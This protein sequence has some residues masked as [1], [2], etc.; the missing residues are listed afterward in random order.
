MVKIL[1][2]YRENKWITKSLPH[3]LLFYP[4]IIKGKAKLSLTIKD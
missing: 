4:R 3:D 1:E 2:I